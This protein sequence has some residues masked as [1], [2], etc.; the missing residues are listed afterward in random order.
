[1]AYRELH[2]RVKAAGFY[3]APPYGGYF[4]DTC[5]YALLGATALALWWMGTGAEVG[6]WKRAAL[7]GGSA[8]SLGLFWE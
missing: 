4:G 1:M 5:R 6:S 2:R 7:I 3:D 8:V